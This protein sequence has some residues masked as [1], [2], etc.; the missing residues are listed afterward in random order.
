MVV[1]LLVGC[2]VCELR[3]G[4]GDNEVYKSM[5]FRARV[6]WRGGFWVAKLPSPTPILGCNSHTVWVSICGTIN[7]QTAATSNQDWRSLYFHPAALNAA[8]SILGQRAQV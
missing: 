7:G 8:S 4:V 6:L 5:S 3:G 1:D 2:A